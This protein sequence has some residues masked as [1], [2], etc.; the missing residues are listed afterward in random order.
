MESK[1]EKSYRDVSKSY[2]KEGLEGA[3]TKLFKIFLA[4]YR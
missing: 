3:K 2:G 4:D 1:E